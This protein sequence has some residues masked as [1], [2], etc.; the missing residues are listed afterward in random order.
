MAEL[1]RSLIDE[2]E[3]VVARKDV[4][5]RAAMMR[6]VT[7]LF[8]MNGAGLSQDHIA[9]F[10]EVMSRLLAAIDALAR[11]AFGDQLARMPHAP[12]R[13]LRTLALDDAIEVA[14]PVLT[15]SASISDETLVETANTKSQAHLHAIAQRP[16]ISPPV[17]DVLVERG[18]QQ[19]I[20]TTAANPGARFSE[21]GCAQ[22]AVRS[23]DDSV[24]A[25]SVLARNDIPREHML[26]L[27]KTASEAVRRD[28]RAA[29]PRKAQLYGYMV[30]QAR[31]RIEDQIRDNSD[32]YAA[33][34]AEVAALREAGE[35]TP[36]R[37]L[38]FARAGKFDET[39]I[40]LSLLCDL[41]IAHVEQ[42][43]VHGHTDQLLVL[44]RAIDLSWETTMALLLMRSGDRTAAM[45][46]LERTRASFLKLQPETAR[47]AI[48][49]YR[50][51]AR[52]S[53]PR[54]G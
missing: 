32:Q 49:F 23:K 24:L 18:D 4:R 48:Q 33:A 43:I 2:L 15:R 12:P 42:V 3:D 27:F 41:P 1:G 8:M 16:T 19:V 38:A 14:G 35:L 34:R 28:L 45:A 5:S 36:A 50:L 7:D 37:L 20:R 13:T 17:T 25:V 39:T 26:S 52:A 47:S 53:T 46:S 51:R 40:A 44:A 29:D 6:R 21:H 22:L 31:S 10:D 9:M 54:R 11:A 30:S